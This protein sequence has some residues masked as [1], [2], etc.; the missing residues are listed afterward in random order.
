MNYLFN[1]SF[2][3]AYFSPEPLGQGIIGEFDTEG[4][5]VR[6]CKKI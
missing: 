1:E 5:G 3:E 6:S 2:K 4:D